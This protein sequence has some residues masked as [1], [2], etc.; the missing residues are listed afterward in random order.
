M[1]NR[2]QLEKQRKISLAARSTTNSEVDS[3]A[4]PVINDLKLDDTTSSSSIQSSKA[5]SI[6]FDAHDS[7][8]SLSTI[9]SEGIVSHHDLL[10][11]DRADTTHDIKARKLSLSTM[12]SNAKVTKSQDNT[13]M[14]QQSNDDSPASRLVTPLDHYGLTLTMSQ[15]VLSETAKSENH[16]LM[17]REEPT[18]QQRRNSDEKVVKWI[19][20][21]M[22][23]EVPMHQGQ[24]N[25]FAANY[26]PEIPKPSA[27]E[28]EIIESQN[29][30]RSIS[31][32]RIKRRHSHHS[33]TSGKESNSSISPKTHD[34]KELMFIRK[35]EKSRRRSSSSQSTPRGESPPR[36]G[37]D[38][39]ELVIAKQGHVKDDSKSYLDL[40][41]KT[42]LDRVYV[43]P[44]LD[45]LNRL[46]L[47][48]AELCSQTFK[49]GLFHSRRT[50]H[51]ERVYNAL[52]VTELERIPSVVEE[53]PPVSIPVL[54][55]EIFLPSL[56]HRSLK[57]K[58]PSVP[59]QHLSHGHRLTLERF[60]S[61][62]KNIFHERQYLASSVGAS[63]HMLNNIM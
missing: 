49:K 11:A 28:H 4:P 25:P 32:N 27:K 6:Q 31:S 16:R 37:T 45:V 8:H 26:K 29:R 53:P 42:N 56:H 9:L 57:I 18:I 43:D 46:C 52:R 40:I 23:G 33:S 59:M 60:T 39:Q 22:S 44:E 55:Y 58:N 35:S 41:K 38:T 62:V 24:P 51:F 13:T 36:E 54:H 48:Y 14:T 19:P 34:R 61:I 5:T 1:V 15:S 30:H 2:K 63:Q 17:Q 20:D 21:I 10:T 47:E 7:K 50:S 3:E 12:S